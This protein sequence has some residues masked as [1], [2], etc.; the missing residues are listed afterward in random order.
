MRSFDRHAHR[1]A[2][3]AARDAVV[4]P[5]KWNEMA[6]QAAIATGSRVGQLIGWVAASRPPLHLLT[7][8]L[9]STEERWLE[10]GGGD[11]RYNLLIRKGV[12]APAMTTIL[13]QDVISADARKRNPVWSGFFEPLNI[14][15]IGAIVISKD[16]SFHLTLG[17]LRSREEG[18]LEGEA[19]R[20][21][22]HCARAAA[23]SAAVSRSLGEE[24]ATVLVQGLSGVNAVAIALDSYA[25]VLGVTE[26]AEA[27]ISAGNCLSVRKGRLVVAP[28]DR[29]RLQAAF[30]RAIFFGIAQ[31][32]MLRGARGRAL[33]LRFFLLHRRFDL[34]V[35][36]RVLLVIEDVSRLAQ[37][38]PA[39]KAVLEL[40]RDGM[41]ADAIAAARGVSRET[42]R[43]QIKAVYA[44]LGVRGHAELLGALAR[45]G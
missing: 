41:K 9:P 32:A 5:E 3:E 13:D 43:S 25:R 17:M 22:E 26:R 39:E 8:D 6:A 31:E 28:A 30:D 1:A 29:Q 24:A 11:P 4:E 21:F 34:G 35:N 23:D 37:L 14:P 44:K 36:A 10:L 16:P 42:A 33:K 15:H 45:S 38:T 12:I 7:E 2:I 19:V 27:L 40:L 18:P 20:I